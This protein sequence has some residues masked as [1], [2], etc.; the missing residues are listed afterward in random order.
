MAVVS[1]QQRLLECLIDEARNR[2]LVN[3]EHA[4]RAFE[5]YT[6]E[7]MRKCLKDISPHYN[8]D[9]HYMAF[10]IEHLSQIK[11]DKPQF[12]I[13]ELPVRHGKSE[14]VTKHDTVSI[15]KADPRMRVII[16]SYSADLAVKFGRDARRMA[17]RI[18]IELSDDR[19]AA[20]DWDTSSGGGVRSV[21]VGG[22]VTGHGANRIKVDDPVKNR[23]EAESD[24]YREKVWNWFQDDLM[25]RREPGC[26]VDVVMSRWHEDDLV[27]RLKESEMKDEWEVIHV[28]ALAEEADPLG[29]EP[30]EA[31]NPERYDKE[32]LKAEE[33]RLGSYSFSGLYQQRPV[34]KDGAMFNIRAV[35]YMD[36]DEM[37]EE[38]WPSD[39]EKA[40]MPAVVSSDLGATVNGDETV[41]VCI[42]GPNQNG[43]FYVSDLMHGDWEPDERDTELDAFLFSFP[44]SGVQ[45]VK[46]TIPQDPGQAGKEQARRFVKRWKT[47]GVRIIRPT[48]PKE[49]RADAFAA[50]WNAGNVVIAKASW[51]RAY[52]G[53]LCS[54]PLGRH[55]DMVDASSDAYNT[56]TRRGG[57]RMKGRR[58]KVV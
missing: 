44:D 22:G 4:N 19:K 2:G 12:T 27:G 35:R 5:S 31:L 29:R 37:W 33:V 46:V 20:N 10:I 45:A 48:G 9:W 30:G 36:A 55:D 3:D 32:Y 52:V 11:P 24:V 54:F 21:G 7:D 58:G 26:S 16:G 17:E 43:D 34:P 38:I 39:R 23:E 57:A 28:P 40:G 13:Y 15:L 14:L 6:L 47:Y 53:Q 1:V 8:W 18:G 49:I 25:T 42:A 50:Q 56:L 51:A 41:M